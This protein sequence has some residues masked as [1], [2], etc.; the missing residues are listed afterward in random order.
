[1][2]HSSNLRKRLYVLLTK[3]ARTRKPFEGVVQHYQLLS[4][5]N[6]RE[7]MTPPFFY[8]SSSEYNLYDYIKEFCRNYSL[9]EGVF[10]LNEMKQWVQFLRTGQV[11]HT[12]QFTRIVRLLKEFPN[13]TFVLLGDDTQE[14]PLSYTAVVESSP[15]QILSVFWRNGRSDRRE[16][17]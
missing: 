17:V 16:A 7:D 3:N 12:G 6:S 4:E 2:S 14:D 15:N 9:P 8:V 10:L 5:S 13:Q 11:K 1:I